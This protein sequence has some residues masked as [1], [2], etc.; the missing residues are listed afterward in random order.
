MTDREA[1]IDL[2]KNES[3]IGSLLSARGDGQP[4][5]FYG[6]TPEGFSGKPC[7]VVLRDGQI[8]EALT[9]LNSEYTLNVYGNSLG[10]A[11]TVGKA[12]Y[13][14]LHASKGDSSGFPFDRLLVTKLGSFTEIE[15]YISILQVNL[16]F[17]RTQEN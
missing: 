10:E 3:A 5:V 16:I 4:A 1:L 12:V 14:T 17:D 9:L 6:Q 11:E 7:I 8:E 13:D 15:D 2:L